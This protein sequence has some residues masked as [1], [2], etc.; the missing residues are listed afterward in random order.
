MR[1]TE[2]EKPVRILTFDIEEWFHLLDIEPINKIEHWNNYEIRI[3]RNTERILHL[4][5]ES[6]QKATFF[7]LG[8]IAEKYPQIIADISSQGY[9]IGSHTSYH[10]L[11]YRLT[12]NQFRDDLRRSID[13][14]ES[15]TGKKVRSF[16]VPGFSITRK[17]LWAFEIIA[18]CGIQFDSSVFPATRAHGGFKEFDG[19][20]PCII[21]TSFGDIKEFP[22]NTIR[23]LGKRVVFSGGGYFR[24]F[25]YYLIHWFISRSEYVMSYFHPRDFDPDQPLLQGLPV[26]RRFKSYTGLKSALTK[27]K[28]ILDNFHFTDIDGAVSLIKWEKKMPVESY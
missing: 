10:Q 19:N 18:Q 9:E 23:F 11:A 25:P 16:R 14:L 24:L 6:N 17:N 3:H 8:W 5:K 13:V 21:N 20:R 26:S 12:P 27:L 15:I 2:V 22:I 7:C 28:K 4:L 1:E